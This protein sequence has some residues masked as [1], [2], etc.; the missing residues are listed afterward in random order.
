MKYFKYSL[1]II[2]AILVIILLFF[3]DHFSQEM[4][5]ALRILCGILLV[6]V[7]LIEIIFRKK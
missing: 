3:D 1:Y 6:L 4:V 2:G 7:V 5:K